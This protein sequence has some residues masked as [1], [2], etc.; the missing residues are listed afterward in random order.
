NWLL[1]NMLGRPMFNATKQ[2]ELEHPIVE[3]GKELRGMMSWI[4]E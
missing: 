4:K 2:K 1:E 3:V